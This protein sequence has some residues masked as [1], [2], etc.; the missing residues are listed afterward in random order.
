MTLADFDK[1]WTDFGLK[2]ENRTVEYRY[3]PNN[4]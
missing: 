4:A 2:K 3:D 1:E